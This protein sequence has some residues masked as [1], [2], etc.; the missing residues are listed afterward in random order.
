MESITKDT[1]IRTSLGT[2]VSLVSIILACASLFYA[3]H[4]RIDKI[5]AINTQ[6]TEAIRKIE[7]LDL[8]IRLTKIETDVSRIRVNMEKNA[9]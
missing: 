6:Q 7:Q 3:L 5:E 4:S 2:I 8:E 1:K 9:K